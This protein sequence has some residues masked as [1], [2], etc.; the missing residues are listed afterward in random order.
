MRETERS[1]W[2]GF[3]IGMIWQGIG[4]SLINLVLIVSVITGGIGAYSALL[5]GSIATGF[6]LFSSSIMLTVVT[7]SNRRYND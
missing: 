2:S 3:Y 7:R 4:L 5:T 6:I 1:W